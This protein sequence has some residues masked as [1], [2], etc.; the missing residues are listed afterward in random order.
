MIHTSIKR[1]ASL[2]KLFHTALA[3]DFPLVSYRLPGVAEPETCIQLDEQALFWSE[4]AVDGFVVAPFDFPE[5]P[6]RWLRRDLSFSGFDF[7][8]ATARTGTL[9][10]G[11]ILRL[12]AFYEQLAE[13]HSPGK[14]MQ[15]GAPGTA[16]DQET[17]EVQVAAALASITRGPLEKVVLSR[18]KQVKLQAD[19]HPVALFELLC[20]A[21]PQAFVSMISL[22]GWGIWLGASP[23]LLLEGDG[24][25]F[26]TMSLAGTRAAT[27]EPRAWTDKEMREQAVVTQYICETLEQAGLEVRTEAQQTI[28]AGQVQHLCNHI[29]A[30]GH[31]GIFSLIKKLHPTP[32]VCGMPVAAAR[33]YIRFHEA[34]QRRLYGGFLGPVDA[35][36]YTRLYV[37]LRS[38]ELHKNLAGLYLGGGIVAGSD[39]AAEWQ[40]TEHKA[41]TLVRILQP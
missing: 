28:T 38:M 11:Q 10:T 33:N 20:K 32:A 15:F 19:Q 5:S 27:V 18:I 1:I 36:G 4:G 26:K 39:P 23:E 12:S 7:N 8:P 40:E 35:E 13:E 34:H 6:A 9:H 3:S 30:S 31:T 41:A 21:Y 17:F 2:Q 16:V 22:P 37:N 29:S 25:Q 14:K 24:E